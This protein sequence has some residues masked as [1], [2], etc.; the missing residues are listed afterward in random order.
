HY[1]LLPAT[2]AAR[3]FELQGQSVWQTPAGQQLASA[4]RRAA[5][6]TREPERFPAYARNQRQLNG[7]RN[8]A[9]FALLQRHY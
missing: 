8:A 7:V 5:L 9:Y 3:V 4:Y 2:A 6:W 1:T